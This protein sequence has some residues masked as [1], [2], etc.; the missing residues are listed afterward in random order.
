MFP[1]FL[2]TAGRRVVVV[3]GGAVG[4]R[5]AAACADAGLAVRVVD[6]LAVPWPGVEWV[7]EAYRPDHLDGAAL[8]VAAATRVVNAMVVADARRLRIPVCD[9]ANPD[10]GDFVFP[11]IV[12]RGG[13]TLAV[14]TG[15][16]SPT[17]SARL[18]DR[19]DADYGP[20]YGEWVAVLDEV[21]QRVLEVVP[22]AAVRRQLLAGFAEDLWL[23]RLREAGAEVARREMLAAVAAAAT[24]FD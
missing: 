16:A 4:R 5:K 17:L 2:H 9:A 7:A 22:D 3:G 13:L 20:E 21:R 18:R 15:G 19:L 14:S 12:R 11:A 23:D 24:K 8:A 1:L 6:P 10:A